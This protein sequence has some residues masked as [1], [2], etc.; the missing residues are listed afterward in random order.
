LALDIE[1]SKVPL[2][3]SGR[4]SLRKEIL[5]AEIACEANKIKKPV[6]LYKLNTGLFN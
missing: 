6:S 2:S 4:T 3:E 1:S 5:L